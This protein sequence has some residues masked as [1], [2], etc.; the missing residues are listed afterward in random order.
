MNHDATRQRGDCFGDS[1]SPVRA[2][3]QP[4]RGH[5]DDRRPK[6]PSDQLEL[7]P[8]HPTGARLPRRVSHAA[9]TRAWRARVVW[10]SVSVNFAVAWASAAGLAG[11]CARA[12]AGRAVAASTAALMRSR[13]SMLTSRRMVLRSRPRDRKGGTGAVRTPLLTTHPL[14]L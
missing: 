10:M 8:R 3:N 9:V 5:R 2:R 12:V 7:P 6:L 11:S 1:G 13:S 14:R 4:D